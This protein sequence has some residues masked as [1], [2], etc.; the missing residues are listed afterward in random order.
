MIQLINELD[1][2]QLLDWSKMPLEQQESQLDQMTV[3]AVNLAINRLEENPLWSDE[4]KKEAKQFIEGNMGN[5]NLIELIRSK[6]P[7]FDNYVKD[8]SYMLKKTMLL[9]ELD[10][11]STKVPEGSSDEDKEEFLDIIEYLKELIDADNPEDFEVTF[12]EYLEF[13][14]KLNI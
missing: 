9:D 12:G 1:I 14:K 13:K 2:D 4:Q 10:F 11:M 7:D 3:D 6:Y 8:A 5:E